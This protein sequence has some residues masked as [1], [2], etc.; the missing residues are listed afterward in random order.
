M[1]A[2]ADSRK[3]IKMP[4]SPVIFGLRSPSLFVPIKTMPPETTTFPKVCEPSWATHLTFFFVL[5]SQLVGSPFIFDVM[6]RSGGPP[7]SGQSPV[8]GSDADAAGARQ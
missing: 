6:F 7:H 8:P 5:T 2:P 4:L 3:A 1:K